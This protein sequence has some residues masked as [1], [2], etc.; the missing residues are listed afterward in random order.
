LG[1]GPFTQED[2]IGIAGGLNLYGYANGDPINFSDAFGLSGCRQRGDPDCSIVVDGRELNPEGYVISNEIVRTEVAAL[3]SALVQELDTDDFTFQVTG[4]DRFRGPDGTHRSSSNGSIVAGS[5]SKSP[6]LIERGARAVDL[7]IQGVSDAA[8]DEALQ[9]TRFLPA[10]TRRGYGDRHT[11][12]A[13]PNE[14][15]YYAKPEGGIEG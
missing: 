2:P 10:N 9:T 12:V 7:R 3:Y 13:L 1:N 5:D 11:H 8:V 4:G 14:I 6:H 15:K